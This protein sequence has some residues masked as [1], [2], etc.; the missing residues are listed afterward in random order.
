MASSKQKTTWS[1]IQRESARREKR[2]EKAAR[3][4]ARKNAPQVP[5]P[6]HEITTGEPDAETAVEGEV[7][8][9]SS[10]AGP[11]LQSSPS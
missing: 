9:S 6:D 8:D 2:A 10:V 1:K 7:S 11:T 3:K 5:M 4:E